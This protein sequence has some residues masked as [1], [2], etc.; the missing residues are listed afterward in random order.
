MREWNEATSHKIPI[1]K[2]KFIKSCPYCHN[3]NLILDETTFF[4]SIFIPEYEGLIMYDNPYYPHNIYECNVCKNEVCD[5]DL[6]WVNKKDGTA[7]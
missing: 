7:L 3:T 1:E 4:Y 2:D 6:D 5:S